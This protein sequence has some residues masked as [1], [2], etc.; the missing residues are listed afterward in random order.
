[1]G[2]CYYQRYL[3]L[4]KAMQQIPFQEHFVNDDD[5]DDGDDEEQSRAGAAAL[6]FVCAAPSYHNKRSSSTIS[7]PKLLSLLFLSLLSCTFIL[8]PHTFSLSCKPAFSLSFSL[9]FLGSFLFLFCSVFSVFFLFVCFL[10]FFV[11][12]LLKAFADSFGAEDEGLVAADLNAPL[13][14]SISNG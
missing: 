5:D 9:S 14:S 13:C 1:M 11:V 8:A 4:K 2:R 7:R 3:K 6:V 12:S 10:M